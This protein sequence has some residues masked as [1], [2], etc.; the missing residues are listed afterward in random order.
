MEEKIIEMPRKQRDL[1]RD[2]SKL[3]RPRR[4]KVVMATRKQLRTPMTQ[5][6]IFSVKESS[7]DLN[8]IQRL[9]L[10]RSSLMLETSMRAS[11]TKKLSSEVDTLIAE[12]KEISAS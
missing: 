1:L 2:N 5:L 9:D 4:R 8:V 7:I 6:P 11:R 3:S 12:E 10:P